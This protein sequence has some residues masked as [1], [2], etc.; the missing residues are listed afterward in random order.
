V[1]E[2]LDAAARLAYA[3]FSA[4]PHADVK[5]KTELAWLALDDPAPF[6]AMAARF[7][8]PAIARLAKDRAAR[9]RRNFRRS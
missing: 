9:S 2:H 3:S 4:P 8:R 5:G 7:A 1:V 6:V